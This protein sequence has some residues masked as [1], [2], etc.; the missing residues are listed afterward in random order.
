[1]IDDG[2][3]DWRIRFLTSG[4]LKFTALQTVDAFLVGG[5]GGG[6]NAN[7]YGGGAGGGYTQAMSNIA[8]QAN[9]NYVIT[10]GAGGAVAT[11]GGNTSAFGITAN[12]GKT[13][14]STGDFRTGGYGGSG[15]AGYESNAVGGSNGGNGPSGSYAGG[16]GQ[17]STTKE[18]HET[19]GVLYAG[20]G[21]W[22]TLPTPGGGGAKNANGAAN[23]GGGAGGQSG[24]VATGGSGI[25]IIRN[26]RA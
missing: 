20:G 14:V 12:G 7:G 15:G 10:I 9:T 21:S 13:P 16:I 5:G 23:T 4:T 22:S 8:L 2:N 26:A 18:F 25:C 3:G 1:V 24:A 6:G 11:N 17:G 19:T